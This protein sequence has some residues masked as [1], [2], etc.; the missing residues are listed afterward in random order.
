MKFK[1]GD[2]IVAGL[3]DVLREIVSISKDQYR[4]KCIKSGYEHWFPIDTTDK[5]WRLDLE[6]LSRKN[7]N[8]DLKDILDEQ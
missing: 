7:F 1:I 2:V 4:F 8:K 3:P 6:Y 5:N